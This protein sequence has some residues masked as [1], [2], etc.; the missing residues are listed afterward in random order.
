MFNSFDGL[1]GGYIRSKA[2]SKSD[3]RLTDVLELINSLN[4]DDISDLSIKIL[5]YSLIQASKIHLKQSDP[6]RIKLER[7]EFLGEIFINLLESL[8]E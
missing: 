8:H 5:L 3:N 2:N 4:P 1:I 7:C 6:V